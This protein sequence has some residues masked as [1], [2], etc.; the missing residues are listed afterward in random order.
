VQGKTAA[1]TLLLSDLLLANSDG[2]SVPI[3][4][5][6]VVVESRIL[7]VWVI[8]VYFKRKDE[9]SQT[10]N[11]FRFFTSFLS[12]VKVEER[13]GAV[14]PRL[15]I[16]LSNGRYILNSVRVNYS[17]GHPGMEGRFLRQKEENYRIRGFPASG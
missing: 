10:K 7:P 3:E 15:E 9:M 5:C 1:K 2:V 13:K 14:T 12:P 17:F 8:R 11:I 16:Y 4:E 6:F